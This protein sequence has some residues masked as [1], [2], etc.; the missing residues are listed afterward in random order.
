[1]FY[2]VKFL[3]I[4]CEREDNKLWNIPLS[5]LRAN[6]VPYY[7]ISDR[8]GWGPSLISKKET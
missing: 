8:G 6:V 2:Y 7:S 4:T 5:H 1:M 3:R